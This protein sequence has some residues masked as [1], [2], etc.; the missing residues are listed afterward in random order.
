[1]LNMGRERE[2]AE[3]RCAVLRKSALRDFGAATS[4]VAGREK[5]RATCDPPSICD[6]SVI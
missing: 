2:A 1:M 4:G 6:Q 3:L 5:S